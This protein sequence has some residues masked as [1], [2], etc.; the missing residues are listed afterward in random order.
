MI[1]YEGNFILIKSD[2]KMKVVS[3]NVEVRNEGDQENE[4]YICKDIKQPIYHS[5]IMFAKQIFTRIFDYSDD[6]R[7]DYVVYAKTIDEIKE[8][9]S[10]LRDNVINNI[11]QAK[12]IIID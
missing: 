11:N 5:D 8:K 4:Y 1:L 3:F 10:I 7:E 9:F 12:I 2:L 6:T